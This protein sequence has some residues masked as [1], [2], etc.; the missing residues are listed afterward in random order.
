MLRGQA[1]PSPWFIFSLGLS[2]L[3][4]PAL[5]SD[6]QKKSVPVQ[7]TMDNESIYWLQVGY[8]SSKDNA[9]RLFKTLSAKNSRAELSNRRI[10]KGNRAGPFK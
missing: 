7:E 10:R 9:E 8:F 4:A 2:W 3:D 5:L 6:F 1:F